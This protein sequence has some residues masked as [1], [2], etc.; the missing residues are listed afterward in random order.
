MKPFLLQPIFGIT[1][2]LIAYF[3]SGK[4][5]SKFNYVIFNR[6]LISVL[7]IIAVL[8]IFNIDFE[9][10]DEGGKYISFFLGPSVVAL[11]VFLYEKLEE[12]KRDLK[13][14]LIAVFA[15][16]I[17]G[18]LSVL[19]ILMLWQVPEILSRSLVA[20]SVTT[21]IAIEIA[22]I[23]NGL[24]EITAGIVIVTGILGNAFGPYV[25][26]VTGIRN[27][28]AIGSA[29]GT[30]AHGIGTAKAFE[31]D[32]FAGTYSGLAMCINGIITALLAPYILEWFLS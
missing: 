17:T 22:K 14:F 21:P 27:N 2:T 7:L 3:L 32:Q 5:K 13:V 16:G 15:G 6:V 26:K 20:K 12:V 25:L 30:S 31:I 10:Y 4:I 1:L 19:A 23:T 11:G 29:L 18:M 8:L 9:T 24:P 28:K